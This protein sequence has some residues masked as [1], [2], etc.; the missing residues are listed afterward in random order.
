MIAGCSSARVVSTSA[1]GGCVAVADSTDSWP[2]YNMSRAKEL[3]SKECPGGYKII[4]TEE[5]VVGQ[6]TTN[7][8]QRDSK[9]VPIIKGVAAEIQQTTHRTTEVRDQKEYR[10]WYEKVD[11]KR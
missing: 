1:N 6:T 7:S 3:M 8:T 5:V 9:E 11:A 2:T 10:I 4:H